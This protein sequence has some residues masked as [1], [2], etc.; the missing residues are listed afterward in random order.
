ME[1]LAL[2]KRYPNLPPDQEKAL[3]ITTIR[4]TLFDIRKRH[5]LP[6]ADPS[7]L[8]YLESSPKNIDLALDL[9]TLIEK[10]PQHLK[11]ICQELARGATD[12]DVATICG[13]S[14]RTVIRAK[15]R[16]R[17]HLSELI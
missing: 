2:K 16:L 13:I 1:I 12:N 17:K 8:A 6:L 5:T 7:L 4:H 15:K 10:L 11:R 3:L 9:R 14:R